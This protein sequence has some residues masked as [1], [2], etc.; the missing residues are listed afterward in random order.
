MISKETID[1]IMETARIEEVI[2]DF[3]QLKKAGTSMK[4]LSPFQDEKTPSFVV[5][6]VKQIF[7]DFSSGRG[8]NVVNF[9][10]ELEN[11]S[12]PEALKWLAKRYNIEIKEDK[13]KS[14]QEL[15]EQSKRESLNIVNEHAKKFF[16]EQIQ[17]G[18]EGIAVGLS[19]FKERGFSD[20]IIEKFELGYCPEKAPHLWEN[21]QSNAYNMEY[22]L[23]LGLIKQKEGRYYDFYR[24]RVMFPIHSISGTVIAFGGRTLRTDKK[25]AKYFNSPE[26]PVYH[27]SN[28]L[29]GIYQ[30]KREMI[31]QDLCYL[32]EGYTDVI[33]MHQSGVE[34]VVASSG[35]SLTEGQIR[36]IKRYTK[37]V[38]ILYDGDAAGIKASFRG[39]DLLLKEGL[40]VKVLLF[41]DGDDP[42][43]FSKKVSE[44]E[45]QRYLAEE[46]KDFLIFKADVL[47][48]ESAKDPIKRAQVIKDIVASI[49]IIPDPIIQ[50]V[51]LKECGE[52][53]DLEMDALHKEMNLLMNQNQKKEI[54]QKA[55]PNVPMD[56]IPPEV[57][58]Q[59]A[60]EADAAMMAAQGGAPAVVNNT[61]KLAGKKDFLYYV[62]KDLLHAMI[63]YGEELL[64]IE[65]FAEGEEKGLF[66]DIPLVWFVILELQQDQIPFRTPLFRK[67]FE[68]MEMAF[69]QAE[70]QLLPESYFLHHADPEIASFAVDLISSPH[71]ISENWKKFHIY[72]KT[73]HQI[74]DKH[75]ETLILDFKYK[76][77]KK[78][79]GDTLNKMQVQPDNDD[80]IYEI[81]LLDKAR[82][83]FA[84]KLGIQVDGN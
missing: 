11:F 47:H 84:K 41:P 8:G 58:A 14:P 56:E 18:Q 66:I 15:Q 65:V 42:D 48:D 76:H 80:L 69:N 72:V 78:L 22:A 60:A 55:S 1:K 10:M 83:H 39:I 40:N 81:M 74:I 43:S 71:E 28:V 79:R 51:Y 16:V 35:T 32:V 23:E 73:M 3:V 13:D 37:N 36:L 52:K 6:P 77:I 57:Y 24:G 82:M 19:Y 26:S 54:K 20:E 70:P 64:P 67:I 2:G 9:I 7:K 29:Y 50:E 17:E 34:N 68:E 63:S 31:K 46:V 12:Y 33:S 4:G 21:L 61:P 62:E 53:F 30:A 38:V 75:V 5:S 45:F 44:E 59:M 25:I 27:K 49:A